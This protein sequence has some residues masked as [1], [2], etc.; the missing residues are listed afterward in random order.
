MTLIGLTSAK[1]S[2]GVTTTALALGWVWPAVHPGRRVLVVDADPAGAGTSA[3]FLRGRS[4][5]VRGSGGAAASLRRR[6]GMTSAH[7][8][9][10]GWMPGGACGTTWSPSMR[11]AP[12]LLPGVADR[13]R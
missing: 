11:T 8:D 13:H 10:R 2:P 6:T 7:A 1:G 4:R 3:G 9:V 5:T 12:M